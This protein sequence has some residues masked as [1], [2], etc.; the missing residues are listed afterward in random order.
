MAIGDEHVAICG[1]RHVRRRI[2]EPVGG[3]PL[4]LLAERQQ[5]L[6]FL[7]QFKDLR[8]GVVGDPE[9]PVRV[10]R[11]LVR[12]GKDVGA[13]VLQQFSGRVELKDWGDAFSRPVARH[14]A[15]GRDAAAVDGPDGAVGRDRHAGG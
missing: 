2:E 1:H 3:A 15:D 14:P 5:H 9:V 7:I 11:H 4:V 13:D 6:A 12:A 10:D 8:P